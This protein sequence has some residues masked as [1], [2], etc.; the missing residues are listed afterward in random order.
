[1]GGASVAFAAERE[2]EIVSVRNGESGV[3]VHA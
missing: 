1:V 3:I 2:S